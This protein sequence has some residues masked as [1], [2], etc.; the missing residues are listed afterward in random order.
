MKTMVGAQITISVIVVILIIIVTITLTVVLSSS[1]TPSSGCI[2]GTP[3]SD[4]GT[5]CINNTCKS[6][7]NSPCSSTDQC[8]SPLVCS[9]NICTFSDIPIDTKP[10]TTPKTTPNFTPITVAAP[11]PAPNIT[12]NIVPNI[13]PIT[14]PDPITLSA[15]NISDKT[16]TKESTTCSPIRN[17]TVIK[18]RS[19]IRQKGSI[20]RTMNSPTQSTDSEC[21]SNGSQP[22]D[23]GFNVRSDPD[24][25]SSELTS[26]C[27]EDNGS[28]YCKPKPTISGT[29]SHPL[30]DV[31]SYSNSTFFLL[32]NGNIIKQDQKQEQNKQLIT[33]NIKLQRL[34][35]FNG[36][37]Y[38]LH[39]N[40]T[41]YV[42]LNAY[43]E[44]ANWLW[45][46]CDWAP[47]NIVWICTPHDNKHLWLAT[48][49]IGLLYSNPQTIIH[50]ISYPDNHT[51]RV[52]GKNHT[53]YMDINLKDHSAIVYPNN[54]K[55]SNIIGGALSYYDEVIA[56]EPK[57]I[58]NYSHIVMVNWKP[59]YLSRQ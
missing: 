25:Y 32:R 45:E 43:Y 42:M 1:S 4:P 57:D 13:A 14:L 37:L 7:L 27:Q 34:V 18:T 9:A 17:K 24:S 38:G 21:N 16:S 41:L 26:P 8:I 19:P 56:I 6:T 50:R 40:G 29:N 2:N 39:T 52:Y 28:F 30:L 59:Y 54:I 35:S 49:N 48:S 15:A 23:L 55:L 5:V 11:N 12:P 46:L 36:Y 58:N 51:K 20:L 53:I 44:S 10:T 3:C 31:C 33:N 47:K 22:E